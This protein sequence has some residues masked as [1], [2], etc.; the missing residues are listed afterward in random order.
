MKKKCYHWQNFIQQFDLSGIS[1]SGNTRKFKNRDYTFSSREDHGISSVQ[2][3]AGR[4]RERSNQGEKV[5]SEFVQKLFLSK[6]VNRALHTFFD[7]VML[8]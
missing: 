1:I 2:Q 4:A 5:A 8:G 7:R 6:R 3:G